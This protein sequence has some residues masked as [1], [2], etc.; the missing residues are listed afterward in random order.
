MLDTKM[1]VPY[2]FT[3]ILYSFESNS[4]LS[5]SN[6]GL[7][8]SFRPYKRSILLKYCFSILSYLLDMEGSTASSSRYACCTK[9]HLVNATFMRKAGM[10]KRI[11]L[12]HITMQICKLDIFLS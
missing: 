10:R 3:T 11:P 7:D 5:E 1:L 6:R 9:P 12:M 4:D 2:R 8:G